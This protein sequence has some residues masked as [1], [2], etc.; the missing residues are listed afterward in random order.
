M[1]ARASSLLKRHVRL[2]L[3]EPATACV[4]DPTPSV[5]EVGGWRFQKKGAPPPHGS[6]GRDNTTDV[7]RSFY[8][9]LYHVV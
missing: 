8:D 6:V 2:S 4:A 3:A 7:D 9:S 5:E 1:K